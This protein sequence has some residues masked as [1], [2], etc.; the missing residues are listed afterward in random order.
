[1]TIDFGRVPTYKVQELESRARA[2]LE[3]KFHPAITIPI[4]ID[5]LVETEPGVKLDYRPGIKARF[6]VAGIVW[7]RDDDTFSV[8]IDEHIADTN[9]TFYRFT[10]AE[11]YAHLILHRPIIE[12]VTSLEMV[13][14]LLEWKGFWEID[15]NAR[16]LAAALLMPANHLVR[17]AGELYTKIVRAVGFRDPKAIISRLVIRL[18]Q[19]YYVSVQAM[20]YRLAEWPVNVIKRVEEAIVDELDFLG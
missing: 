10:V 11:E 5:F 20:R 17:D 12:R 4:D 7:R 6:S 19:R 16:R 8:I 3:E 2:L 13:I 18:S 9:P 1:V 15:R 14:H